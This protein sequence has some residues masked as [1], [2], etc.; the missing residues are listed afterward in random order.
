LKLSSNA[1]NHLLRQNSGAAAQLRPF[2]G[3][4]VRLSMP[5]LQSTLFINAAGEFDTASAGSEVDAEIGLTPAAALRLLLVP[6]SSS[7]LARL[8]GDM[9]LATTVA[10]VLHGLRWDVEEDLSRVVGDIPAHELSQAGARIGREI[11][12]QAQ[13]LS[14]M[15]AE[16]WLEEQPLIAK[17]RHL[18]QFATDVDA[19]R[20]DM[21]RLEKRIQR[22][23]SKT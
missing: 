14:G 19:L 13:S 2:A 7:G 17:K 3:K 23:E 4:T 10:K 11:A 1:L 18:K 20:D 6:E 21:E 15:L 12:R 22:L 5:P 8:Q 9:P 16:Y